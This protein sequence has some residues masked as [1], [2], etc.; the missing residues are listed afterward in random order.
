MNEVKQLVG[1]GRRA[2]A[3]RV[4]ADAKSAKETLAMNKKLETTQLFAV[5]ADQI[6]QAEKAMGGTEGGGAI[7]G[8]NGI[9][10]INKGRALCIELRKLHKEYD[11]NVRQ[12]VRDG[13]R[14]EAKEVLRTAHGI[15][16]QVEQI[17]TIVVDA[18]VRRLAAV[19]EH[20]KAKVDR[21]PES[22]WLEADLINILTDYHK[23][24]T[25]LQE[26]HGAMME[27]VEQ[28]M[29]IGRRT[30]AK[31]V[32]V[33]TKKVQNLI[34]ENAAVG[35]WPASRYRWQSGRRR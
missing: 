9:A 20:M 6:A 14:Q 28:L 17:T 16:K 21:V 11:E 8:D 29:K 35:R 7:D 25:T 10:G 18:E 22:G 23:H 15:Q 24:Y 3:S 30:E 4:L 34:H 19:S 1:D 27:N 32:L 31:L 5:N 26:Q 33:G 13:Q 12:L 2:E